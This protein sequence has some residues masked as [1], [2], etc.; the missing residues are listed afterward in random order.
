MATCFLRSILLDL[1]TKDFPVLFFAELIVDLVLLLIWLPEVVLFFEELLFLSAE[2]SMFLDH[3]NCNTS[4]FYERL[5][6][7][8]YNNYYT[9]SKIS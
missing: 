7:V 6:C 9:S 8:A 4:F 1:A 3:S 5:I 2:F